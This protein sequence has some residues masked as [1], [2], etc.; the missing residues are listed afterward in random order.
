VK[1]TNDTS[2]FF[3]ENSDVFTNEDT[4]NYELGYMAR[5]G[6][7]EGSLKQRYLYNFCDVQLTNTAYEV[8]GYNGVMQGTSFSFTPNGNVNPYAVQKFKASEDYTEYPATTA[9]FK[10]EDLVPAW[11]G[12]SGICYSGIKSA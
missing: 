12:K 7:V 9:N 5:G 2:A 10:Y 8:T 1:N 3:P 11:D 4:F 6:H